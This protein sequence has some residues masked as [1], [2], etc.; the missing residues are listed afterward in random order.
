M[1]EAFAVMQVYTE[2]HLGDLRGC[3]LPGVTAVL[4]GLRSRGYLLGLL[5]GNLS[6][7][8]WAKMRHAGLD[9]YFQFGG[10]GEESEVRAHLVPVALAAATHLFGRPIPAEHAVLIGDT[11]HDIEAGKAHG[12][13][14]AGVA[15]GM[16]SIES[17]I[18]A[19]ADVVMPSFEDTDRALVS[20][21]QLA[22]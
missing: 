9:G 5:T 22:S 12:T 6:R 13:K 8:A 17:L 19:G 20:L 14:T 11:P 7:I 4:D 2:E 18:E 10:F 16:S 21:M 1:P 15:T 3:V